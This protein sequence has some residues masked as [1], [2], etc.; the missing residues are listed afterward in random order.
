MLLQETEEETQMD[1]LEAD[2]VKTVDY[3]ENVIEPLEARA[4]RMT[5]RE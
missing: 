1:E 2:I 3:Y 4:A 5:D